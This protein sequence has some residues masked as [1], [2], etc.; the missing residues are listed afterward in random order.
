MKTLS[1]LIALFTITTLSAIAEEAPKLASDNL[2]TLLN[3]TQE[4]NL[5]MFHAVCDETMKKAITPDTL[6]KISTQLSPL[7]KLGYKKQFL[8][9]IN[10]GNHK[11]YLWKL[12]MKKDDSPELLAELTHGKDK[13]AG[14]FIR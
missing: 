6:N 3:A 11:T 1:L 8:G 12:V 5:E 10:R 13:V 7:L 4:N 9:V 2:V 14:F